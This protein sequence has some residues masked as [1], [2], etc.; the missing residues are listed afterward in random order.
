M[1]NAR[2]LLVLWLFVM[3]VGAGGGR[4][5]AQEVDEFGLPMVPGR[6]VVID[7]MGTVNRI[8]EGGMVV[9][10]AWVGFSPRTRFYSRRNQPVERRALQ[11]GDKV[12]IAMAA[13]GVTATAV[14]KLP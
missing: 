12:G 7:R 1:R 8:E 10:D 14:W 2:W 6:T 13:D 4:A 5:V 3:A 11:V 9:D